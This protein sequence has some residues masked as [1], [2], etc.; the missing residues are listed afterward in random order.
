MDDDRFDTLTRSLTVVGS[1]RRAMTGG[2]GSVLSLLGLAQSD[3]TVAKSGK[4]KPACGE[5]AKCEKGRCHKKNGKKVCNRGKCKPKAN[6]T[7]CSVGT[8]QTGGCICPFV[9]LRG[10][11]ADAGACCTSTT[12]T[13]CARTGGCR[14]DGLPVCCKLVGATCIDSCDCCGLSSCTGGICT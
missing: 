2:L 12:G 6:G 8:C 14:P 11:C 9:G 5:C 7:A 4:C 13:V 3:E 10:L 1:R